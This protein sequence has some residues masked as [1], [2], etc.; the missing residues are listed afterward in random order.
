MIVAEWLERNAIH[1]DFAR[2][3]FSHRTNSRQA[4]SF[5]AGGDAYARRSREEQLVVLAAV[6]RLLKRG[7]ANSRGRFDFRAQVGR[8][9][10]AMQIERKSVAEIHR[11]G[12]AR[13][14]IA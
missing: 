11:G 13:A 5:E 2:A 6:Q 8:V 10:Q 4:K 1:L 3:A 12:C 7:S 9:A 14:Q